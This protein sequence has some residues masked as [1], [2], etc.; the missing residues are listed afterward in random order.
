MSEEFT[1]WRS[2]SLTMIPQEKLLPWTWTLLTE[3]SSKSNMSELPLGTKLPKHV[4]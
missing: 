2:A 4:D 1:T 3:N